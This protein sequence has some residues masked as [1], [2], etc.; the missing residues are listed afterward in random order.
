MQKLT[1][2]SDELVE[3]LNNLGFV[4]FITEKPVTGM[5]KG[6]AFFFDEESKE[7]GYCSIISNDYKDCDKNKE[8][9]LSKV[10]ST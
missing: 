7:Y 4:H 6:R 8:Y 1:W 3:A 10:L 5:E 9:I 2:C